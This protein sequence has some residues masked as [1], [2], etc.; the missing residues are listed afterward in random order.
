M[1]VS[2]LASVALA[3]GISACLSPFAARAQLREVVSK[4]VSVGR[5]AASLALELAG[6]SRLEISFEDG[7]VLV[8]G[9]SVGRFESGDALDV[10]WRALLGRAVALEDGPLASAL[11][12]WSVPAELTG[13][14]A[15]A[16]REIDRALDSALRSVDVQADPGEPSVSLGD[17]GSLVRLL[18]G[19]GGRL[20]LLDDALAGL[21]EVVRV[22]V[23]EDAVVGADEVVEGNLIVIDG[24]VRIEGEVDGDVVVVGGSLELL[25]GSSVSGS[26]R[27]ADARLI[28]NLGEVEGDV[29]EVEDETALDVDVDIREEIRRELRSEI[30]EEIEGE[31]GFSLFAPFRPVVRAVGGVLENLVSILILG[32]VG[33]A[34]IAFAGDRVEV[35]AETARRAPGRAAVVGLAGT[36]LLIPAW[37][38]GFVALLVS[39]VGIPVAIAWLPAFPIAACLAALVGYLAVA[40]NAGE[41]LADSELP[42][43]HW[44]RKSNALITM[45]GG[46]LGLMA[47]FVAANVVSVAPFLG[48]LTGLLVAA[49]VVVTFFA[50][51][52][53]F[54]AVILTRAGRRRDYARYTA[55]EAWEAAMNVDV[56]GVDAEPAT[57]GADPGR[58]EGHDA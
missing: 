25:E 5:S 6:G 49:G 17:P 54:G 40:R 26:V 8:D 41:W 53:G 28:R 57:P 4:E 16:A 22:H 13:D 15:D 55:D 18:L 10:T 23:A 46:L 29:V 48:F 3:L 30:R 27:L 36:M 21:D 35:I 52:I 2:R 11:A 14:D 33:A 1:S 24:D 20:R 50:V 51:Q 43:T 38:I 9:K 39:I 58:K 12:D 7:S 19:E 56:G 45:V 34:V 31:G 44:I 47:L 42:L 37:V 32:L